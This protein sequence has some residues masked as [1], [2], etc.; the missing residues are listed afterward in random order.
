MIYEGISGANGQIRTDDLFITS[1]SF[2][3][4]HRTNKGFLH[5]ESRFYRMYRHKN[6]HTSCPPF[7]ADLGP[8]G[9]SHRLSLILRGIL[10]QKSNAPDLQR[11]SSN[12]S[13]GE[14]ASECPRIA[15]GSIARRQDDLGSYCETATRILM[16]I[17]SF[18]KA[19]NPH[20]SHSFY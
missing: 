4:K 3:Q 2:G 12:P 19:S 16:R 8:A 13:A 18:Q 9:N 15:R 11:T 6:R 17:S 1:E 20:I 5:H 14:K 10:D 7:V